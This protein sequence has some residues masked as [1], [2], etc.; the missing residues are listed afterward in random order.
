MLYERKRMLGWT[1]AVCEKTLDD[2]IKRIVKH[3]N[4]RKT[5]RTLATS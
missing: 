2:F 5:L 1:Q 3:G 4:S